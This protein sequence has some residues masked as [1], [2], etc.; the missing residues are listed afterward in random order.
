MAALYEKEVPEVFDLVF[1][2]LGA[3]GHTASLFPDHVALKEW[4][5]GVLAVKGGD[6]DVPRLTMTFPLINKARHIIFLVSG[7]KKA[8]VL[9]AVLEDRDVKLPAV[10]VLPSTGSLTWVLDRAAASLLSKETPRG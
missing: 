10:H 3:D 8:E 2:G 5:R 1:L 7:E 9:K 6:P 4:K